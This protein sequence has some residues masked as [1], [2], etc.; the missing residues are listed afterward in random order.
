MAHRI[1]SPKLLRS[2]C[3]E[4]H[5][6]DGVDPREQAKGLS[7]KR[8]KRKAHQ[9]CGQVAEALSFAFGQSGDEV[10]Q[11]L[12]VVAVDLAPDTRRLLVTVGSL[13]SEGLDPAEVLER[14]GRASA[15][16]RVEVASAITRR[17]TPTLV[18]RYAV[19]AGT[20]RS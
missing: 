11:A 9:L 10:L 1:P 4:V 16:L 12:H 6:D 13:A 8:V 19:P 5:P 14:L 20:S 17:K 2:L 7:H 15:R 3:A 18:Y